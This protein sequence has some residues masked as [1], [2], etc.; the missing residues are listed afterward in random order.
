MALNSKKS[1]HYARTRKELAEALGYDVDKLTAVQEMKLDNAVALK[2]ASDALRA[3][4]MR[5]EEV[6]HKE[7]LAVTDGLAKLL[8]KE[9]EPEPTIDERDDPHARLMKIV[10]DWIANHETERAERGLSP[11]V[12]DPEEQ[13]AKIDALEAELA[14]LRGMLPAPDPTRALPSP[15]RPIDV[16]TSAITPPGEQTGR[17]VR[18]GKRFTPD[19]MKVMR[20]KPTIE[21]K[22]TTVDG[23]P[24]PAGS[25]VP[26]GNWGTVSG[27]EAKRRM[28]AVNNDRSIERRIMAEPSRVSGEPQPSNAGNRFGDTTIIWP[29]R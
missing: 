27:D 16:P 21:G 22:V 2:I 1:S 19:D 13:Q 6:D 29:V 7:L 4:L 9:C 17:N 8:P 14:E 5:G 18:I 23:K 20:P 11:R 10:D 28:A 24:V 3:A 25:K 12:H 26:P 15:E